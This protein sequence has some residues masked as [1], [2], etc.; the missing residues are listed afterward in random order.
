MKKL[1]KNTSLEFSERLSKKYNCNVYLKREDLQIVRSFKI[2]GA[3]NKIIKNLNNKNFV[4]ASAG[5]H[6]QGVAYVCNE[7]KLNS[8]IFVPDNTPI[9]KINRIKYFGGKYTNLNIIGNNFDDSLNKSLDYSKKNNMIFVHPFDD[10]DVIEGQSFITK[11]IC[12]KI[13]PDVICV[14]VGGG[15][16]LAGTI[17]YLENCNTIN[18][19]N[20]KVY[21]AEPAG[22]AS[23]Y[24]SLKRNKLI[25]LE[26]VDKF[27]DGA[28][29]GQP[30]KITY[31]YAKN[32]E[33]IYKID[34]G[35]LC[36]TIIDLYQNEGIIVEPAGGLCV[37]LLNKLDKN[38]IENKNVVCILSGG[39]NDIMRYSEIIEKSLIFQKLKHYFL[40]NIKQH[41]GELR[42][43][44]DNI[45]I[46]GTDITRF[47]YIKKN[48]KES[49][50]IILGIE[51]IR[52][53]MINEIKSKMIKNNVEY[54]DIIENKL[55]FEYLF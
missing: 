1:I 51:V 48:N 44:L 16:L 24:E 40:I 34:N 29:V 8:H 11:E 47:E 12:E 36:N 23:M 53:D 37:S 19:I 17:Y 18:S 14:C 33:K 7:L 15:G 28:C 50:S 52:P 54:I 3:Y 42:K 5:N 6:A 4:T 27:V 32:A 49:G 30:G 45:L 22:A 13:I 43:F 31:E 35:E 2:R 55:A 46:K 39:N 41:P 26:N 20:C 38:K 25:K 9:Q 10:H 21:G